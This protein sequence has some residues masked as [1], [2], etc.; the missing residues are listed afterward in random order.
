MELPLGDVG[1]GGSEESRHLPGTRWGRGRPPDLA[2][3]PV[4][5]QTARGPGL[6]GRSAGR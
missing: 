2:W 5:L 1:R 4:S 3:L 6:W